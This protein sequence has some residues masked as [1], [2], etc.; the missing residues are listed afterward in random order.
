MLP[1]VSLRHWAAVSSCVIALLLIAVASAS[2]HDFTTGG[3]AA[4][5]G[6]EIVNVTCD[7]GSPDAC[8]RG[9]VLRVGGENLET[10]RTVVF[11]GGR[12]RRD[13]RRARASVA[14]PHRVV[15][16]VPR[17]ARSGRVR[18]VSEATGESA[19]TPPVKVVAKAAA[20]PAPVQT[21][22][23]AGSAEGVFPILGGKY[24]FGTEINRF[25]G[26]RDHQGQD[27]FA[28]CGTPLVSALAGEVTLVRFQD[29]A[30]NYIVIKADDGTSQAYMH[31]LEPSPLRKGDRVSAG[32]QIGLVGETGRASGCHLHF[33][34]WTA[35]GWYEGGEAIDPL[36]ALRRWEKSAP[37]A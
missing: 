17:G 24:D 23:P 11:L 34:L 15:V 13:D 20:Q 26:G 7:A 6:P 12:G 36:P 19:A 33:E 35:P 21:T 14:S 5:M 32:Q 31:M 18:V 3:A 8:P 16:R 28:K 27:V 10:A 2:A 29:R 1:F 9:G 30:G 37:A 22:A 4:P 25:G